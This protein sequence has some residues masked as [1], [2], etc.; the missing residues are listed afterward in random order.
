MLQVFRYLLDRVQ[1]SVMLAA[2][3]WKWTD[4]KILKERIAR[5]P[6][7]P[8]AFDVDAL[9][10]NIGDFDDFRKLKRADKKKYSPLKDEFQ[11]LIERVMK[12][13]PVVKPSPVD[14]VHDI[15]SSS[16]Q[17]DDFS[18]DE[19]SS[20]SKENENIIQT[21][22]KRQRREKNKKKEPKELDAGGLSVWIVEKVRAHPEF[23]HMMIPY[24]GTPFSL[25]HAVT[26][27]PLFYRNNAS[28]SAYELLKFLIAVNPHA[29]TYEWEEKREDDDDGSENSSSPQGGLAFLAALDN[30]KSALREIAY[31]V[32]DIFVWIAEHYVWVLDDPHVKQGPQ[33]PHIQ[34]VRSH[35]HNGEMIREFYEHYP[36]GLRQKGFYYNPGIRYIVEDY[37]VN[38]QVPRDAPWRIHP[39]RICL[40]LRLDE[41]GEYLRHYGHDQN[42]Q[43]LEWMLN[44]YP[45]AARHSDEDTNFLSALGE[46]ARYHCKPEYD[47]EEGDN[48]I[49][50]I[51]VELFRMILKVCPDLLQDSDDKWITPFHDLIRVNKWEDGHDLIV[52]IAKSGLW[53][54]G[55]YDDF[56]DLEYMRVLRRLVHEDKIMEEIQSELS[57][58]KTMLS[59]LSDHNECPEY[60]QQVQEIFGMWSKDH[61]DGLEAER[62]RM[63]DFE[64][65]AMS[66]MDA[67]YN[68]EELIR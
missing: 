5:D 9:S 3:S 27:S 12:W 25:V 60:V 45:D 36:A 24:H 46:V 38:Y 42:M 13:E 33:P 57:H 58:S 65:S 54:W 23:T 67:E 47:C 64:T 31:A 32:P 40:S 52:S 48:H 7:R 29:L 22:S 34:F 11:A 26:E 19:N 56:D 63:L 50:E 55:E 51:G 35:S 20:S 16:D 53:E 59:N 10:P 44:E 66:K 30:R 41:D 37:Y 17:G 39:F 2:T 28:V 6:T 15:S 1:I 8:I 49:V 21:R 18:S 62:S 61:V 14:A 4:G 68:L 43:L